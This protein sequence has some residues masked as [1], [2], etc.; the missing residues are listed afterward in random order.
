MNN[1]T[2]VLSTFLTI[3]LLLTVAVFAVGFMTLPAS[4]VSDSDSMLVQP[5]VNILGY[6]CCM[7]AGLTLLS[8]AAL[9]PVTVPF[10]LSPFSTNAP[11]PATSYHIRV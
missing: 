5:L 9:V 7:G 11:A 3:L 4:A 1:I 10:A 6:D 2:R 8:I